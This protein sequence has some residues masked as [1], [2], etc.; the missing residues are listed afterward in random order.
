MIVLAGSPDPRT[1]VKPGPTGLEPL[2]SGFNVNLGDKYI[3]GLLSGQPLILDM[4][5]AFTDSA[6]RARNPI[7]M[8]LRRFQT[9]LRLPREVTAVPQG[10]PEYR[11][12][13]LL[14]TLA[15][16]TWLEEEF[17]QSFARMMD[18]LRKDPGRK[19]YTDRTRV[20]GVTV[21]D[22]S[23]AARLAVYGSGLIASD[24]WA[25]ET[26]GT[27]PV[28]FDLIGVTIDWLR[29]RPPVP[30]GVLAKTYTSYTFPP[31]VDTGRILWFPLGL[32][33][34]VV[35]G[36]GAGVWVIRRK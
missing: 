12:T 23:A 18:E 33:V 14:G 10:N 4:P 16:V 2:L 34:L 32:A 1:A 20:V 36:L 26:R 30:T 3:V 22:S 13:P 35:A 29:D 9:T 5:A 28:E 11:A 6:A 25:R 21:A 8:T 7:A 15:D 17:P 31:K 27:A 24:D 19:Q